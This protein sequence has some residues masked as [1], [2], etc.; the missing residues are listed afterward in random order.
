M[1]GKSELFLKAA[2]KDADSIACSFL[3][4]GI[5]VVFRVAEWHTSPGSRSW[6]QWKSIAVGVY[7]MSMVSSPRAVQHILKFRLRFTCRAPFDYCA[8]AWPI[9]VSLLSDRTGSWR[10]EQERDS[11][12]I[13]SQKLPNGGNYGIWLRKHASTC[14]KKGKFARCYPHFTWQ[15]ATYGYHLL[16]KFWPTIRE[17]ID[18]LAGETC[19]SPLSRALCYD[20]KSV[21]RCLLNASANPVAEGLAI[22]SNNYLSCASPQIL[23]PMMYALSK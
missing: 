7:G 1:P 19:L 23:P 10:R 15:Q 17:N 14:P 3:C 4:A 18:T 2:V 20:H 16:N 22:P 11:A 13:D 21:V 12:F 9:Y 6:R 5:S 8:Q